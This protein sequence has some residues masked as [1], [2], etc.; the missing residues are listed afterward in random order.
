MIL[1]IKTFAKAY[2]KKND[3]IELIALVLDTNT[4]GRIPMIIFFKLIEITN[5][6]PSLSIEN[7]LVTK[8]R[9][10]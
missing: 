7:R 2:E 1:F 5:N 6:N 3:L 4:G 10:V 8:Q 9:N